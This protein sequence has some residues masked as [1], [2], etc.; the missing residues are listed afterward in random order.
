MVPTSEPPAR[1]VM[2]CVPFHIVATSPDSIFGSRYS[3][4]SAI[5]E[6]PDQMD[7][8]VG[9]ADRAHQPELGLHEQILQ[10]VFGDCGQ[11]AIHAERAGAMAHGVELEIAEGDLLHLAIGGVIVDPVFVAA[12][13]VARVQHRRMLVGDPRQLVEPAACECAEAIEMRLEAREI[14]RREI[15][16][17]QV[18]QAA[19]DGV[20]ILSGAIGRDVIGAAARARRCGTGRIPW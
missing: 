19:V 16:R 12:E 1:S 14:I 4:S 17:E 9:D 3:C 11:R 8:G 20:E 18:A 7:R 15:M 5:G 6:F 10:R 13:T 2:N